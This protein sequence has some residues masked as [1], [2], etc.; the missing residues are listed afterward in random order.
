MSKR[1]RLAKYSRKIVGCLEC[2]M[3]HNHFLNGEG[4]C[5]AGKQHQLISI[6]GSLGIPP[7]CPLEEYNE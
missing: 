6:Y 1:I 7:S 2:P 4:W 3:F 5:L